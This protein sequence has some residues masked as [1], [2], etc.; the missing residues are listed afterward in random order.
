MTE[1][2]ERQSLSADESK[3][4]ERAV[5]ELLKI[6]AEGEG[7]SHAGGESGALLR[8]RDLR[9]LADRLMTASD[10]EFFL[11]SGLDLG[12]LES[13]IEEPDQRRG[14]RLVLTRMRDLLQRRGWC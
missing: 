5:A 2:P 10:H 1:R 13:L 4:V 8:Q 6:A 14:R 9:G 3:I 12:L 7:S 11:I